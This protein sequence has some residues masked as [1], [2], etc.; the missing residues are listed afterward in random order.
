MVIVYILCFR[1][2]TNEGLVDADE[3]NVENVVDG[4]NDLGN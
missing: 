2:A 1:M 3:Q 4:E